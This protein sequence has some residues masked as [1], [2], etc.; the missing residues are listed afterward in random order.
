MNTRSKTVIAGMVLIMF[1]CVT[2][3]GSWGAAKPA[4]T[5]TPMV[6]ANF[7]GIAEKV[8]P[9]V[10]HIRTEQA[11]KGSDDISYFFRGN[12]FPEGHPFEEFFKQFQDRKRSPLKKRQGLGSG[13][14]IDGDGYIVTNNH[15]IDNADT[16]TVKLS[17]G[18]EYTGELVGRDANTDLALIRIKGAK[19]LKPLCLGDS[20]RLDVGSWVVAVGSPFGLEQTV[21]A[22]IVSA[23]GRVIGSGPY[24]DFIQ[25]DA[26]INPGNSGGPLVN[27]KGE[28]VGINTA[29]IANGQGIGFAI[30]INLA[31]EIISQLKDTGEVTRAWLG[32]GIQD[33]TRELREYYG[34]GDRNGV[35]ITEVFEDSPAEK[36]GVKA[37]DIITSI[38]GKTVS[39]AKELS[40]TV[41]ALPVEKKV[42][43]TVLR[44]GA[45]KHFTVTL[46][47]RTDD[48]VSAAA[49]ENDYGNLGF[50][51]S[52][53]SPELADRFG[54]P[55]NEK[56]VV[57]TEVTP[58]SKAELAGLRP[59]DL[60]KGVN[61]VTVTSLSDLQ[62]EVRKVSDGAVI[63]LLVKRGRGGFMAVKIT[64]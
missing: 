30:P 14:I 45:E 33:L 52:T 47:K 46:A 49:S 23:K 54:Y 9:G 28:V 4:D 3:F 2:G 31:R 24:D 29:I 12:P 18:E 36:G 13:F 60:I 64:K 25:T 63:N 34:T 59:G 58:G 48:V 39:S 7:S 57:V 51:V 50:A 10:V 41:A 62:E 42:D 44:D 38:D 19:D 26:S 43:V 20:D 27:M 32:V 40:R 15:V 53:M 1:L 61:T 37:E 16:M 8:K 21:T 11:V 35:L 5:G 56:G 55:D 17:T 22:G 6:P